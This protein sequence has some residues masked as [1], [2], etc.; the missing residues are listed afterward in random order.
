MRSF[1]IFC[2]ALLMTGAL[3]YADKKFP[4]TAT[5]AVPS[6]TGNVSVDTDSN[7]NSKVKVNV[8]HLANP[9][10]LTPPATVYVVWIQQRGSNQ[11]ENAGVLQVG[12]DLKGGVE[13]TTPYRSFDVF[14]TAEHN[15]TAT[16]PNGPEILRTTVQR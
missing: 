2:L 12:N 14:V 15:R 16:T 8:E 4:M 1:F 3:A 6:A 10:S 9:A 7:G 13:T 11:P 5:A